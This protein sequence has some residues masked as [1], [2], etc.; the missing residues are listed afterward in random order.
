MAQIS[1]APLSEPITG[2]ESIN[3][4]WNK[5]FDDV[6]K[7]FQGSSNLTVNEVTVTASDLD[8][9]G[10]KVLV[11]AGSTEQ[12]KIRD[13]ILSGSG[14]NFAASGDRGISIQDSSGTVVYSLI[15]NSTLESLST[16]RWGDASLPYPTTAANITTAST[17]GEDIIATYSGGTTDHSGTGSLTLIVTAERVRE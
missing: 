10:T 16:A 9:S 5:W 11:G 1:V 12:Y 17:T 13:I 3:P 4:L 2:R 7:K 8:S 6:Y 15:P 14:T